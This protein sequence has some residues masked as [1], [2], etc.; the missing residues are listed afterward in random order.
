M[1]KTDLRIELDLFYSVT[2]R[3]PTRREFRKIGSERAMY[4][5]FGGMSQLQNW[6]LRSIPATNHGTMVSVGQT[7]KDEYLK[8]LRS[9]VCLV[10]YVKGGYTY[11]SALTLSADVLEPY[12]GKGTAKLANDNIIF[13]YDVDETRFRCIQVTNIQSCVPLG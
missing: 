10:K 5:E 1:D 2:G 12:V 7:S 11:T 8:I 6:Y 13:A 3:F 4:R 9:S